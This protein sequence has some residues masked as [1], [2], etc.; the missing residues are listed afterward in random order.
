MRRYTKKSI[1]NLLQ[2][3]LD[4][5]KELE[6]VLSQVY[7]SVDFDFLCEF[8]SKVIELGTKIEE[9]G[10]EES[11]VHLL[12]KVCE[13][14]YQISQVE[15]VNE[16]QLLY[17]EVSSLFKCVENNIHQIEEETYKI[18]FF[19]Y[20]AAMWDALESIYIA[21]RE[22]KNCEC[23]VIPIPYYDKKEDGSFGEMHYEGHM[24]PEGIEI[25][26]WED[27]DYESMRFDIGYI[28]N[29]YDKFNKVTSVHPNFYSDKM[30][31][32]VEKLV[33]VPYFYTTGRLSEGHTFYPSY[34]YVDAIIVQN[35]D[36]KEQIDRILG[37]NKTYALGSP[38]LDRV[39]M[40][41]RKK[42]IPD[43]WKDKILNK[44]VVFL[45]T[46]IAAILNSK[47]K[48]LDRLE[49]LFETLKRN[50]KVI[51][52][53]R[54]HPLLETTLRAMEQD[55]YSRYMNIKNMF[56]VENIGIY[57]EGED[58]EQVVGMCDAYLGERS[59]SIV[60]MFAALGK[61]I[62]FLDYNIQSND[63]YK[64]S[65]IFFDFVEKGD[66]IYFING[67]YPILCKAEKVSGKIIAV[68]NL[69]VNFSDTTRVYSD[70]VCLGDRIYFSPFCGESILSYDVVTGIKQKTNLNNVKEHNY[71]R[72][73]KYKDKLFF[74]PLL[75]DYLVCVDTVT[76]EVLYL[77][78]PIRELRRFSGVDGY[79]CMF[80]ACM[81]DSKLYMASSTSNYVVEYDVESMAIHCY[82]VGNEKN[83]YWDM[84]YDG[85]NFWLN[86][87]TSTAIV[88]WNK[89]NG[90][91]E[92]LYKYPQG[93][94]S[95]NSNMMGMYFLRLVDC[96][97]YI[98]AFPKLGNMIVK[99][100]KKDGAMS[101]FDVKLHYNE[102]E[103][104]T[105][106]QTWGS[107]Y[108][109]VKREENN[110]YAMTAYDDSL[111]QIDIDSSRVCKNQFIF[112]QTAKKQI[113][114]IIREDYISD[115]NQ[116]FLT[117]FSYYTA[118]DY[119]REIGEDFLKKDKQKQ[120]R[121]L[122]NINNSDGNCG[123]LVHKKMLEIF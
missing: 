63:G 16:M 123:S 85:E 88:K 46:S 44:N 3:C 110:I 18:A 106:Y 99:I 59:S 56:I 33:Y 96:G 122:K 30:K 34:K 92:E 105:A 41:D 72:I 81:V 4:M 5:E 43:K 9:E 66:Y 70:N 73:I 45:N 103:R 94:K 78:E 37:V 15:D 65:E 89:K 98:L 112:S 80:A 90:T 21:A 22:D 75:S 91:A 118:E 79:A 76:D 121:F 25:V 40:A 8:Q 104:K 116:Y 77:E 11:I 115:K 101:K 68:Q 24:L 69:N 10:L 31:S 82:R 109:F 97:E 111:L 14:I 93:F 95:I 71:N 36:S 32:F 107:N 27:I 55:L 119:L 47:D 38:K 64:N 67:R 19:P 50:S 1:I 117:E 7:L 113:Y 84:I 114:D 74:I 51:V 62:M 108:Y 83:T 28:H 2:I 120:D 58:I 53:W 42:A 6:D 102:G 87:H 86:P 52:L 17:D 12:E 29:P 48:M 26:D 61:P 13:N 20:K 49:S 54:P 35:E 39:I 57:D 100:N 23:Y 60:G